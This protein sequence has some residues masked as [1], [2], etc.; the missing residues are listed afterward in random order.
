MFSKFL[1]YL[2]WNY[3]LNV[4][5]KIVQGLNNMGCMTYSKLDKLEQFSIVLEAK[6]DKIRK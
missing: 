2:F 5:R 3:F 1:M 6:L 4:E